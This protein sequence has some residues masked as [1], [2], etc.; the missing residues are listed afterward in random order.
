MDRYVKLKLGWSAN[1]EFVGEIFDTKK[2]FQEQFKKFRGITKSWNWDDILTGTMH[3]PYF[4]F[5]EDREY[6]KQ[7]LNCGRLVKGGYY[8]VKESGVIFKHDG[9]PKSEYYIGS[10]IDSYYNNTLDKFCRD[11][12]N[13]DS[14]NIIN[15]YRLATDEEIE[16]L[17]ACNK[18]NKFITK[19]ELIGYKIK[20]E[21]ES[22]RDTI[23]KA[24]NTHSKDLDNGTFLPP[25]GFVF[26]D[27][28]KL[29]VLDLWFEPVYNHNSPFQVGDW[30]METWTASPFFNRKAFKVTRI[31]GNNVEYN[32][33]DISRAISSQL[34]PATQQEIAKTLI[35]NFTGKT[36]IKIGS[37]VKQ[38]QFNG[39]AKELK[40]VHRT[41]TNS[42]K[43][44]TVVRDWFK[45]NPEEDYQVI[46]ISDGH[47]LSP[48]CELVNTPNVTIRGYD[49]DI[50]Q[51]KVKFGCQSYDKSF[52]L[53]LGK[54]LIDSGLKIESQEEIMK[55]VKYYK[56]N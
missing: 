36:G 27:A 33:E 4:E 2:D 35:D 31:D 18:A 9:T 5:V 48:Y 54:F 11:N 7:E 25:K 20:P 44:S 32:R 19:E 14:D 49:A 3:K 15:D 16:W 17:E 41:E 40:V 50:Q 30:V 53:Q 1:G 46:V 42:G 28:V 6:W 26:Q 37:R 38:S 55:V 29:K 34:R 43:F 13:F 24:L 10:S 47:T 51:N 22:I 8:T 21:F 52:V 56:N 45:E 12:G 23:A 39:I